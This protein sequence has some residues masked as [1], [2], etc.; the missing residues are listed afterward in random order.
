VL[1]F[2]A[3]LIARL[4]LYLLSRL[5]RRWMPPRPVMNDPIG[6]VLRAMRDLE[7]SPQVVYGAR[8]GM[9]L[10]VV[11]LLS[12][13]I[14]LAVVRRRRR[15]A[16]VDEDDRESVWSRDSLVKGL[17]RL[18]VRRR[19]LRDLK[20]D[21]TGTPEALAVRMLYR[22]LLRAAAEVGRSRRKDQTPREFAR[23]VEPFAGSAAG[24]LR[25]FTG[26]YEAVRYGAHRP[27]QDEVAAAQGWL[28][29]LRTAF[30]P[31]TARSE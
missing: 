6:D 5:P 10:F 11:L 18:F 21:L 12:L 3:S 28:E 13:A 9:V 17:R 26:A 8:W 1:F 22:R 31:R 30:P 25:A 27:S 29:R 19:L 2:F 14:V 7:V 23:E 24:D 4:I 16:A 20:D 15:A